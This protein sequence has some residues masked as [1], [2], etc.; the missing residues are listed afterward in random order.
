MGVMF[1]EHAVSA[2]A[3]KQSSAQRQRLEYTWNPVPTE[4]IGVDLSRWN[5]DGTRAKEDAPVHAE[6]TIAKPLPCWAWPGGD[7]QR[8]DGVE[9]WVTEMDSV[10]D[11]MFEALAA[12]STDNATGSSRGKQPAS[13]TAGDGDCSNLSSART[14]FDSSLLGRSRVAA[15]VVGLRRCVR[16]LRSG[17][18]SCSNGPRMY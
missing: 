12:N 16:H 14:I 17:H 1:K 2:K 3:P 13:S 10:V 18:L 5:D 4:V 7:G 15:G 9:Q 8:R 6:K 11:E